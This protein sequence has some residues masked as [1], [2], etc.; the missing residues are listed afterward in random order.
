M[1]LLGRIEPAEHGLWYASCSSIGAYTQ[2]RSRK[3]ARA[4]LADCVEVLIDRPGF[5]VIATE[6]RGERAANGKI[7]YAIGIDANDR[8]LLLAELLKHQ[9]RVH[10]L[11][12]ADVAKR[13][14]SKH[15]NAYAA[16]ERGTR[17]PSVTKYLELLAAVAPEMTLFVGRK[18]INTSP[19]ARK[20]RRSSGGAG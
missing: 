11:T 1:I 12:I 8:P 16:Y 3:D 4:M 13:L 6:L 18:P 20:R 19:K 9:R 15:V 10:K 2:G 5:K 7:G 17:E 14:G